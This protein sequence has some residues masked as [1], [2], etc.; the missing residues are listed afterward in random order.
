MHYLKTESYT[1]GLLNRAG[2]VFDSSVYELR[3]PFKEKSMWEFP[4][5]VMDVDVMNNGGR[6]QQ[7]TFEQAQKHTLDVIDKAE[8]AAIPYFS[9][10]FHDQ[11]FNDGYLSYK[12]WYIWLME[13]FNYHD[14]RFVSF[15]QAI[16]EL[17]KR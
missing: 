11:N 14:Y 10:L 6:W 3:A 4:I 1:M 15:R 16:E 13:H 8:K 17:E 12:H 2:Y 5:S 9:V 7:R